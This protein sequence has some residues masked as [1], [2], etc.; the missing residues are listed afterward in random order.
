MSKEPIDGY[1]LS[2]QQKRL[3]LLQKVERNQPYRAHCS[4][5]LEGSLNLKALNSA[6]HNIVNRY[7]IL[8]TNF[9]CLPGMIVP[10]QVINDRITPSI[11]YYNFSNIDTQEQQANIELIFSQ[12]SQIPLD[13][14]RGTLLHLSLVTL[15]SYKHILLINLPSLLADSVTIKNL[16]DQISRYYAAYLRDEELLDEPVQYAD[17]AEWQNELIEAD[18]TKIAGEYWHGHTSYDFLRLTLPFENKRFST[19]DFQPQI[20]SQDNSDLLVK[21]EALGQKYNTSIF[22]LLLTCFQVLFL[23]LTGQQDIIVGTAFDGRKYEELE[24]AIGLLAKYVPLR[25]HLERNLKFSEILEQ[26]K[27]SVNN[28]YKWQD[29]FNFQQIS[30]LTKND[31]GLPFFPICFDFLEQINNQLSAD[32]LLSVQ[33]HYAYIDR[34][35]IKLSCT[36]SGNSLVTDFHYDSNLF[37]SRD[38]KRLSSYFQVLLLSIIKNPEAP[39]FEL[40]LLSDI[41][42]HQLIVEFNTAKANYRPEQCIHHL[43]EQQ[44][45]HIPDSIAVVFEDQHLTYA[46][47]NAR[48]NQLAHHLQRLGAGSEIIVGLYAERSLEIVIGLLSILKTGGAYLPLDP[49]L[50]KEG[51]TFRLQDAQ[52]PILLTQQQLVETLPEHT[53]Q[54]VVLDTNWTVISSE[55][56]ENLTSYVKAEN[57]AYVVFTSGSTGQPKGVAVEHKQLLNYINAIVERLDLSVCN[58]FATV[59]T[60]AADLGNTTIFSSLCMGGCLHIVSQ[61]RASNPEAL[62]KYFHRHPI[63]CL[64]IVPSHLA[65]LLTSS[66]AEQIL[67][68]QRLILGGEAYSWNLIEQ[69]QQLTSECLIFNHYGPT[70]ATVGVLTYPIKR[71]QT[72]RVSETVL[73]GRPIANTQVYLLNSYLQP[74]PIGVSGELY[75]GGAGVARGYLN[76]PDLTREKFISNPFAET[77]AIASGQR[78]YKT[79]DLAR[80]LPDGNI[81]F[82]GRIDHQVKIHGFRI[83]LGEIEVTLRKHPLVWETVV[84]AREDQPGNKHLVAYVVPKKQSAL[85]TSQLREYLLEKLPEYMVPSTFV[86][87]KTLPLLPNGKVDR[88]VLPAPNTT[89]NLEGTFV[90]P[91]TAVEK[92][93]AEIWAKILR[94][95]QV[96]I[97]DKFFELGGDSILSMQIIA[98]A[99]QVGLHITPKHLFEHQTIAEL[100]VVAITNQSIQAEQGLVTGQVPLTPIQHWFFKQNLPDSHHW[101]QSILL[102]V[103]QALNQALLE[104]TVQKLLEHHDA[105]RLRFFLQESG[106]Q[107]FTA[108]SDSV[109][110]CSRV[111]L[112]ALSPNKQ[113]P[114]LEAAAAELQTSLN[115]S[116]GPLMRVIYFDLGTDKLSRLL[117]LIHHL[118]VDGVS[119][120]ILLEDLQTVYQQLNHKKTIQLPPKTTSFKHWAERLRKYAQLPA[121]Q[122][123]LK[124]WLT[125]NGKEIA[126]LPVD[127]CEGENTM[128]KAGTISVALSEE[129]TQSL[130]REI[131][132]A[133]QTQINDILLTA[134][135]Q[136]FEQWM[137]K[138]TAK[139]SRKHLL[140]VDLEGHGREEIFEDVDLSRTVGWFT[141]I[142][143]VLLD[144]EENSSSTETLEMVKKQ[145]RSIPNRGIGYGV[146]RY[147]SDETA[148]PLKLHLPKAE[149]RLNYLGQSDQVFSGSAL[150]APAQESSGE[151]RSLRGNRSYLIDMIAIIAGGQLRLDCIYSKA[152]HHRVTIESLVESFTAALRELI[153]HCKSL[154]PRKYTPSDFLQADPNPIKI[155]YQANA[156]TT[157]GKMTIAAL[158]AEAV[159]NP[160]ISPETSFEFTIEPANILLTGATGFVGAFLL[161]ELLQQTNANIYCLVRAP[162]VESGNKRLQS[163]LESYLLWNE[164][165]SNR[166]I[167]VVGDLSEPLLGLSEQQFQA[168]AELLDVIYHNAAAINLVYP[169]STLKAANVLGTQEVLK[170]ASQIKVKPVHYISTL[171][172]LSSESHAEVKGIQELHS[173]NFDHCQVPSSGYAQTKWVAEKLVTTAHNRGLPVCIYRLGR[174]SGHSQSGICNM[175]DRLYRMLKGFIQLKCAPDVE[176]IVDMTPVDYVSKAIVYLSKQNKSLEKIFHLSNPHPIRSFELFD[177]IRKFGYPL[178][179]MSYNQWEAELLNAS[180]PS[181]NNPLYPLIPFFAGIANEGDRN[182]ESSEQTFN[183]AT[184]KFDFQ[185]T[186]DGLTSTSIVCPPVDT[187]LLSTYF[188]YLIQSGFLNAPQLSN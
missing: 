114:A 76:R 127:F 75:I 43:F 42:K 130:L 124:Y 138:R 158:N 36:R 148:K 62:A 131:P 15:S 147:L 143:P 1:R 125:K 17:I 86:R 66:H 142:F 84:L 39:I 166:I 51:L 33:K 120:R 168:M 169:Y 13:L 102:E 139:E 144:I 137:G 97:Y 161:H 178:Q 70:E 20:Y 113:I 182:Q 47:L 99:N 56:K 105:L 55:S 5:L 136:A 9:R 12:L 123:E 79:G 4:L 61:E 185:N 58:S 183:L 54:V 160:T 159:L 111:D 52:V 37:L 165:L 145:L 164:S 35:K 186:I 98:K 24:Q 107:Q 65:A 146:L 121:L 174:V 132:A 151:S 187:K 112:S 119:W 50:P 83:E 74:V 88:W 90:A 25:C 181:L 2:P 11:K 109:V 179:P 82:L 48:A 122:S 49:A 126:R 94:L 152:V 118:A 177:W 95:E 96:G 140:L 150:F 156:S 38:I 108:S 103:Q 77:G 163:H 45:V 101:N 63:D 141:T 10:L 81:E 29:Y 64:K 116:S 106:W 173:F 6:L 46:E 135:V 41:E 23:H 167:P 21:L 157:T 30:G 32:I 16:V 188:S 7:E 22:I 28:A 80:Y 27:Q 162:N 154:E 93:L 110:P 18:D 53:T 78:L 14:E 87:L 26:T 149:I 155:T 59:S 89:S 73:I 115:L 40:E 67:P 34:F 172:V 171:S 184:L 100:A 71:G 72:D 19:S 91:R 31:V 170:L 44:A 68:R 180:E 153:N 60:F 104:Q 85:K 134:L 133:Y 92:V 129:E 57:L 8:R 69:I 175:N 3:W 128:A 176:T 117:L